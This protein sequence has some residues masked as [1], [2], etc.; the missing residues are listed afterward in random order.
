MK[1]R[2]TIKSSLLAPL[3]IA[4]LVTQGAYLS[5]PT[6]AKEKKKPIEKFRANAISLDRGAAAHLDIVIY[7]WTHPGGAPGPAPRLRRRW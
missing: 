5:S 2:R 3:A 1:T 4:L 7:E 6:W